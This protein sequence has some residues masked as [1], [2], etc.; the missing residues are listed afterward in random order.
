M[1]RWI[2]ATPPGRPMGW[3]VRT[4]DIDAIAGRLGLAPTAGART[5]PDG[6]AL[7]WKSAGIEAAAA[8]PTLPFFIEWSRETPHPG[9]EAIAHA[10]G[11]VR[12]ERIVLGGDA[13]ALRDW[14]GPAELPVTFEP[15][16]PAIASIILATEAG[17]LSL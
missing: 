9:R 13:R 3:V 2:A 14:I 15:G 17:P 4:A 12:L 6:R 8:N 16:P 5:T 10:V 1:G 7:A 11:D